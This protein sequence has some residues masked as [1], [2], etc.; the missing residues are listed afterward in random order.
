M[1]SSGEI[2]KPKPF[3]NKTITTLHL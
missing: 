3:L 2:H 1:I